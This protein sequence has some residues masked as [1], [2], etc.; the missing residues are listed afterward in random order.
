MNNTQNRNNTIDLLRFITC[1]FVVLIHCPLP[2]PLGKVII[3]IGRYGVPLFL[4]LSGWF[5]YSADS[6]I[7]LTH[8]KKKLIDTLQLLSLFI[9]AY[10]IIN[11][12]TAII[13]GKFFLSWILSYINIKTFISLILFNRAIFLGSTG[14]YVIMLI[15]VYIIYILLIKYRLL[16]KAFTLIPFLLITNVLLGAFT[17]LPFFCYGNFLFTGLPFFLLGHWLHK[18]NYRLPKNLFV[19]LYL[20]IL[21]GLL[22][23][24][25]A[26]L[27]R[28]AYCFCGSIFMAVALLLFSV[29]YDFHIRNQ[30][31]IQ[32]LRQYSVYLFVLHCG[33]RDLLLTFLNK[34]RLSYYSYEFIILLIL[35]AL[36]ICF[37]GS[38]LSSH[39]KCFIQIKLPK[40]RK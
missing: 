39:K 9:F 18:N 3:Y 21:G 36:I 20:F 28:P 16:N 17:N 4:L 13:S 40:K 15:Y 30:K 6:K 12:I 5:S 29:N 35:F 31:C 14:Y 22:S 7:M 38:F 37:V 25:E 8:A 33:L 1:F 10:F 26:Y 34:N 19:L 23:L 11:S 27:N 24:A 32:F 2:G